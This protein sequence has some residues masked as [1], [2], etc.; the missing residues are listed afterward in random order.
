MVR[1]LKEAGI[2]DVL[3]KIIPGVV[4]TCAGCRAWA[5]TPPQSVASSSLAEYFNHQVECDLM[6]V[7]RYV[8]FH[9]IDRCT[10]WHAAMIKPD[11]ETQPQL[12]A[13]DQWVE[14]HGPMKQLIMDGET[15][16]AAPMKL[17]S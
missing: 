8:I 2:P 13:I 5:K 16:L 11:R 9:L 12:D 15:G 10:R 3:C 14:T 6:F 1:I 4:A 17:K 7:Y